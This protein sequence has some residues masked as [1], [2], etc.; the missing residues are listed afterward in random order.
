MELTAWTQI[1]PMDLNWDRYLKYR[2]LPDFFSDRP[3]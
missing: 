2:I 1:G 3:A